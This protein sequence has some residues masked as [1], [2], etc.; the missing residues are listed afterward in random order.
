MYPTSVK[1]ATGIA[2]KC[3]TL[4]QTLEN[5]DMNKSDRQRDISNSN[6]FLSISFDSVSKSKAHSAETNNCK[7]RDIHPPVSNWI[8]KNPPTSLES[9]QSMSSRSKR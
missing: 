3:L 6:A 4:L 7:L 2:L 5:I 8:S 9:F 1:F